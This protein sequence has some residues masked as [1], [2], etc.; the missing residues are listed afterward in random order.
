MKEPTT[1]TCAI[2]CTQEHRAGRRDEEDKS[3]TRQIENARAFAEN[4]GLD[5]R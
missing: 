4:E 2:L 5:D 1:I 3:V